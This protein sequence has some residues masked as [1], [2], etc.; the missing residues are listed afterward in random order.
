MATKPTLPQIIADTAKKAMRRISPDVDENEQRGIA[1]GIRS[2][3]DQAQQVHDLMNEQRTGLRP[4]ETD[5]P[6]TVSSEDLIAPTARYGSRPGEKRLDAEGNEI[7]NAHP[8]LTEKTRVSTDRVTAPARGEVR[9][10]SKGNPAVVLMPKIKLPSYDEGTDFVPEDQVAEVHQG[11]AILPADEAAVYRA[12]RQ[13]PMDSRQAPQGFAPIVT[14]PSAPKAE[15]NQVQVRGAEP[16]RGTDVERKAIDV[17]KQ[18][19]MV[20]GNLIKLGTALLNE[21][22]LSPIEVPKEFNQGT[23]GPARGMEQG[24]TAAGTGFDRPGFKPMVDTSATPVSALPD[25]SAISVRGAESPKDAYK[26]K[27]K[28]YDTQIQSALDEGTPEG[29]EKADRL[30]LAKQVFQSKNP[31]GSAANHPG[32]LGELGHVAAKV[33]NIA[34]DIIAPKTLEL[35]P[36][37]QL[38]KAAR[39]AGTLKAIDTDTQLTTQRA[40]EENKP[41]STKEWQEI[42]G[43]AIDPKHPELGVQPAFYNKSNPEEGIKF[44]NVPLAPKSGAEKAVPASAEDRADYQQRI[45]NSGLT[46]KALDVY[47]KA[48]ADAT[49]AD[50]DK[51]FD[52]ATKLRGM[53]QKDAETHIQNQ[54]R[55]DAREDKLKN[56]FYT[57]TDE[58]GTHLVTGDK[59][60]SLPEGTEYTTVKDVA[61]LTGE[62]RAMNAVQDSL[63]D[64]HKDLEA[65][66]EVFDNSVARGIIQT[67]TEQMNRASAGLLI[68]GTGGSVPIPS[69]FGD[70]INTALQNSTLDQKTSKAVKD[71]IADY[72]AMKDKAMVIQMMMQNGKMG[73]GGMQAF[74]SIVNQLPG[75][76]TPD[77]ATALRQMAALQRTTTGMMG[78]YPEEYGDYK[79]A[80][81]Y[82]GK[83]S[84]TA[85]A[86][87]T[88]P[89]Y[90]SAT[91]HTVIGHM[92]DGKYVPLKP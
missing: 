51:R 50:L 60:D 39:A 91:D 36:G 88:N 69:G 22:H 2:N 44:G 13:L 20:S 92:V 80:K 6:R 72:K 62:G 71:Y 64:L 52:E 65:H 7:S 54:M 40:A 53:N 35:I 70:M 85:P 83:G 12:A 76:S 18:N 56:K 89:V 59:L 29:K 57:Y 19:A 15:D 78:K 25:T 86:G 74:E 26:T 43:G 63:N 41:A 17:D 23:Q 31:W 75:G 79:K 34:G 11:E 90:K 47:S 45:A 81:P 1:A 87:A 48:P 46:G 21:Q 33:G 5:E 8:E 49:K 14:E 28:D 66:P 4:I 10:D 30:A 73:R 3:L 37:T 24:V 16:V 42:T 55:E 58:K 84:E 27:L 9:L 82:E 38:N 77:S 32:F 61:Q 68:A 67:T